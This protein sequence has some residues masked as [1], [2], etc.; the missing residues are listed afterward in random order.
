MEK[1]ERRTMIKAMGALS[2]GITTF[3]SS[4]AEELAEPFVTKK[5]SIST[6]ILVV[7]GGTAGTIV[8]TE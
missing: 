7:G 4:K 2:I 1:I 6:D 8:R 5:K 3:S